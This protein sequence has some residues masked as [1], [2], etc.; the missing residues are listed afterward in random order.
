MRNIIVFSILF[1]YC[2]NATAKK[3]EA[4]NS[5]INLK[6]GFKLGDLIIIEDRIISEKEYEK[7]PKLFIE[8]NDDLKLIKQSKSIL[9]SS[10]KYIFKNKVTYQIYLK[11]KSGQYELP[12]HSYK[13]NNINISMPKKSYW[14]TRVAESKLNNILTNSVDQKK[15][16]LMIVVSSYLN[17]ALGIIFLCLLILLYKNLDLPF[18]K[19]MNGPFAIAHKKIKKLHKNQ[20]KDNYVKAILIL[21]DAFNKSFNKNINS[22]NFNELINDNNKFKE[23]KGAIKI[24]INLSS[25][26]IYSSK[27]YFSKKRFDEIYSFAKILRTIERKV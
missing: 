7:N 18:L 21:T 15:P 3:Y 11:T 8:G 25:I 9:Q 12:K 5:I 20:H 1:L 14:F 27:T 19:K 6:Y 17:I 24:F 10:N 4:D 16:E 22:S 2:I 26:E 23:V 13:V